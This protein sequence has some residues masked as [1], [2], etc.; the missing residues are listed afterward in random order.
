MP[1]TVITNAAHSAIR[2]SMI[3]EHGFWHNG[4]SRRVA[5][6]HWWEV[7]LST[8]TLENLRHFRLRDEDLSSTIIRMFSIWERSR[9]CKTNGKPSTTS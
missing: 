6:T 8:E 5:G 3:R 2:K 7:E 9:Q 1:I 4:W